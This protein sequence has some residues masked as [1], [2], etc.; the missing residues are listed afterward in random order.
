MTNSLCQA[1]AAE[2]KR[3]VALAEY[4]AKIAVVDDHR[5]FLDA[6]LMVVDAAKPNFDL[7]GFAEPLALLEAVENGG[8]FDMIICDLIMNSMNGLAFVAALRPQ[9]TIPILML[10]GI[11][12]APPLE[13]MKRLGAQGFI[14]KSVGN[15]SLL[16]AIELILA[17]GNYF[18]ET[19]LHSDAVA[20]GQFGNFQSYD[21]E[22]TSAIPTLTKRQIEVLRL[23]S[24]GAS[25]SE[26]STRLTISENTVKSHLKQ[27]FEALQV[28]KRTACVRAAQAY[29]LI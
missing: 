11:N 15:E 19:S 16:S 4:V 5:M 21:G 17:G 13:E 1:K 6:I 26:I 25:N 9:S 8:H 18:A 27:I 22:E 3:G 7:V 24:E 23:I 28:N 10:S 12:T 29:G 14:H 20:V 2:N